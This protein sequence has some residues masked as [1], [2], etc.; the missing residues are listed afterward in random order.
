MEKKWEEREDYSI[1]ISSNLILLGNEN[2]FCL[3]LG[4]IIC[5]KSYV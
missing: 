1:R 5:T 3:S 4:I 2:Y